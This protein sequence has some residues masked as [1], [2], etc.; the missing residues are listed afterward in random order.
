MKVTTERLEDCQ[1]KINVELDAADVEKRLRQTAR[2]LSRQFTV[3]G[4]RRGKAPYHAVIRVFGREAVQQ[5]GLEDWGNDLYEE[6]LEQID[7]EPY[8]VGQLEEVEWDPFVMTVLLPIQPE[9]DLGD[10]RSVRVP[11]E[12][13]E[14]TEEK[15]DESLAALQQ[16]YA[17]W[18]PVERPA[19]DGDQVVLDME[20]K[21]GDELFM[22]NEEHEMILDQEA[23][24]PVPG[25][26]EQIIGMSAGE[27]KTFTLTLP[28]DDFQESIAGQEGT[29]TVH[30]HSV[31]EQD[32]PP[33]DDEL[34]MMAGDYDDLEALR[35][36]TQENMETEA[37][38]KAES[39]YFA[40]AINAI[41]EGAVQIE[42]PPQAIEHEADITLSQIERNL[43]ASGIELDTYLGMMGKTREVYKLELRPA[44]EERLK[45]RLVMSNVAKG[46]G[47]D[48]DDETIDAEIERLSVAMGER[49]DDMREMLNTPPGRLSVADDLMVAQVQERIVQI[50]RGE[51]PDLEEEAEEDS[52]EAEEDSVEAEEDSVE[53]EEP[54]EEEQDADEAQEEASTE[55]E[56][57]EES[58]AEETEAPAEEEQEEGETEDAG[59]NK[60]D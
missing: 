47:L 43:A 7:Y 24:Y 3:P 38:Q 45:Q 57:A 4:Y 17:Q 18:V 31:K 36:A 5:Q 39:E 37:L 6:A 35:L 32:L 60:A 29:I 34:A 12:V 40:S 25:F 51:A 33:L 22:S 58:V 26:H 48:V 28:E 8:E 19:E 9:V 23:T 13:D 42:Y 20:G 56:A 30:L 10:Y 14:I 11:F 41:I 46:E 53:A 15:V 27:E 50:A 44:A 55:E 52:V 21:A 59:D 16:Q 1:V 2:Q 49:A 54:A